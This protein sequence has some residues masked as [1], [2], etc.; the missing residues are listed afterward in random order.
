MKYFSFNLTSKTLC[1]YFV[2][3]DIFYP[4]YI[5]AYFFAECDYNLVTNKGDFFT[6]NI[7]PFKQRVDTVLGIEIRSYKRL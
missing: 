7:H 6:K 3:R 5:L 4:I 1:F 2:K